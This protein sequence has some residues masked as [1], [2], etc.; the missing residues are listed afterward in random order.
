MSNQGVAGSF[1]SKARGGVAVWLASLLSG[2]GRDRHVVRTEKRGKIKY[3]LTATTTSIAFHPGVI[4]HVKVL[5][6][7]MGNITVYDS[8]SASGRVLCPAL[9]PVAGVS[10]L[11]GAEFLVGCTIVTA[12]AMFLE[13]CYD[14]VNGRETIL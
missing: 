13:V 11:E 9:T 3:I 5:G 14:E 6:G 4:Q 10:M 1:N 8:F 12:S 7:I 2:E